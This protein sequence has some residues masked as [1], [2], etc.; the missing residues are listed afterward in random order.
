MLTLYWSR[1]I[2]K[3]VS[4]LTGKI[5]DSGLF[6][7]TI[8][9]WYETLVEVCVDVKEVAKINDF[10]LHMHPRAATIL[11]STYHNVAFED[12]TC[13]L[14]VKYSEIAQMDAKIVE[15]E[16]IRPGEILFVDANTKNDLAKLIILDMDVL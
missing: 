5:L 11:Y 2:G 9:E 14:K 13:R 12:G 6:T 15:S 3:F 10:E 16:E 7:G 4:Q 8:G 1:R